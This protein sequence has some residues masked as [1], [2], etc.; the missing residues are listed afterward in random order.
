MGRVRVNQVCLTGIE[1][2]SST[3]LLNELI[4]SS[5]SGKERIAQTPQLLQAFLDTQSALKSPL[6][7]AAPGAGDIPPLVTD[8][9]TT[10]PPV[11]PNLH[12]GLLA[13]I[14]VNSHSAP[15]PSGKT[16][17]SNSQALTVR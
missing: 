3:K 6:L 15:S 9:Y 2:A 17:S 4:L 7:D 1:P 8:A 14:R 13:T 16:G 5:K 10:L 12:M 11:G